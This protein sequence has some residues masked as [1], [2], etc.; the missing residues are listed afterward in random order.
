MLWLCILTFFS[1]FA[2]L[3][4]TIGVFVRVVDVLLT[5]RVS[6]VRAPEVGTRGPRSGPRRTGS[7]GS[8]RRGGRSSGASRR[9]RIFFTCQRNRSLVFKRVSSS[10]GARNGR[11]PIRTFTSSLTSGRTPQ[12]RDARGA[13]RAAGV[14]AR[15]C[16]IARARGHTHALRGRDA[17]VC[18]RRERRGAAG[19]ERAGAN[20]RAHRFR[21]RGHA[22][23]RMARGRGVQGDAT[24]AA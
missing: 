2:F 4:A 10:F 15:G 1:K 9:R 19:G 12:C 8:G 5:V 18:H 16:G 20:R 14:P 3:I 13:R 22:H 11:A 23:H 17:H 6:R 7:C 21:R 24:A